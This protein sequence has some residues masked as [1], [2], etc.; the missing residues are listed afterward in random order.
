VI[1]R[2]AVEALAVEVPAVHGGI[3]AEVVGTQ[4]HPVAGD[5]LITKKLR[6]QF[7]RKLRV[8][9]LV[10]RMLVQFGR[11]PGWHFARTDL[12]F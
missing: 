11:K 10:D 4:G 9:Y 1:F 12:I 2:V 7:C 6:P 5:R 8:S 3:I